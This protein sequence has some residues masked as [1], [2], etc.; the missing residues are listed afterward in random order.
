MEERDD[1]D[2]E[3]LRVGEEVEV[4]GLRDLSYQYLNGMRG[5][6]L[7][8]AKSKRDR[9]DVEIEGVSFPPVVPLLRTNLKA[10]CRHTHA[11]QDDPQPSGTLERY[12]TQLSREKAM[13]EK[14]MEERRS[15]L[16]TMVKTSAM[17][18]NHLKAQRDVMLGQQ[19]QFAEYMEAAQ[20]QYA[21]YLKAVE[22]QVQQAVY[23]STPMEP[24]E[25][26][27]DPDKI[28]LY[29][30]YTPEERAEVCT[31][32]GK[33]AWNKLTWEERL[34]EAQKH[35]AERKQ[36]PQ[37]VA[38]APTSGVEPSPPPGVHVE[39]KVK[40]GDRAFSM[41][42]SRRLFDHLRQ[43]ID[44]VA[45]SSEPPL[46]LVRIKGE[47]ATLVANREF[48]R[49]IAERWAVQEEAYGVVVHRKGGWELVDAATFWKAYEVVGVVGGSKDPTGPPGRVKVAS[50]EVPQVCGEYMLVAGKLVNGHPVW[51]SGERLVYSDAHGRWNLNGM[52]A[53]K[54]RHG[55]ALPH[56]IRTGWVVTERASP[57]AYDFAEDP[58][59][60]VAAVPQCVSQT[61]PL[62]LHTPV[63]LPTLGAQGRVVGTAGRDLVVAL[64]DPS[65]TR[66]VC[67]SDQ[68]QAIASSYPID[69]DSL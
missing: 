22:Q 17:W 23:R 68:V 30:R 26:D 15:N 14:Q 65:S 31:A 59:A 24:I 18:E 4:V 6:V 44:E 66:V 20:Q 57:G 28:T 25:V 36:P 51:A 50:G 45:G 34:V 21:A 37:L 35:F 2:L 5:K 11:V 61:P 43:S 47:G 3:G 63:A 46:C 13:L 64:N 12:I 40:D 69:Y 62:P 56:E 58:T 19:K 16:A 55:G 1:G 67:T 7:G 38:T 49:Y 29:S 53:S 48:L 42:A 10:T 33:A 8:R 54:E 27:D 52:L 9:I 41:M 60:F 39:I 32:V